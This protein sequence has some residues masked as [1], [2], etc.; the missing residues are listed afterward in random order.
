MM[1]Y[2]A[3]ALLLLA[4]FLPGAAL[5]Q[6]ELAPRYDRYGEKDPGAYSKYE[7]RPRAPGPFLSTRGM[8]LGFVGSWM[9]KADAHE[10][11]KGFD[12]R[13]RCER[14]HAEQAGN[15]H[16]ARLGVACRECHGAYPIASVN[17]YNSRMNPYR[18]HAQV[19][20]KCHLNAGLSFATY[21][22]HG[23]SP[24]ST[25]T[26]KSF[27]QLFWAFWV[28]AA[29]AILTFVIFLPFTLLW[30]IRELLG[31]GKKEDSP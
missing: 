8:Q 20:A 18:R 13:M 17:H 27:P 9:L 26:A 11:V 14:C 25:E 19:C 3:V 2:M 12:P 15:L 23:P 4:F 10:R 5:A 30:G 29:I 22:V 16:S 21:V 31:R 6:V 7:V 1:R 24:Y 28:M